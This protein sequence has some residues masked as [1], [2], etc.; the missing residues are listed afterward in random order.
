MGM[1]NRVGHDFVD[2][3]CLEKKCRDCFQPNPYKC[4]KLNQW[5]P[6][7]K[8]LVI[9]FMLTDQCNL[10]CEFCWQKLSIPT[11]GTFTKELIDETLEYFY[12]NYNEYSLVIAVLGGE[13]TLYPELI[14]EIAKKQDELYHKISIRVYSNGLFNP[15]KI[16]KICETYENITFQIS[17]NYEII[18][19]KGL[20]QYIEVASL[21]I[22]ED[23]NFEQEYKRILE[24]KEMG[25]HLMHINFDLN[26]IKLNNPKKYHQDCI[27]FM[28]KLIPLLSKEFAISNFIDNP[29][30]L[31]KIED[32]NP[33][34]N[35]FPDGKFY[36]T[37]YKYSPPVGSLLEGVD[38]EQFYT[39][40]SDSPCRSCPNDDIC[41]VRA[42][43]EFIQSDGT[44]QREKTVCLKNLMEAEI[45]RKW[46]INM[47]GE[48]T[49]LLRGEGHLK[50]KM[51]R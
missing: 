49:L 36:K 14:E 34:I 48:D 6:R 47:F 25:Y 31:H 30:Y 7:K 10:N 9:A 41:S 43:Q 26:N 13:P 40:F 11:F 8:F 19:Y 2:S 18:K 46:H 15:E 51:R 28:E 4:A 39:V 42:E 35:V 45:A 23:T 44:E 33:I 38:L 24:I 16:L 32:Y 17:Q 29:F 50:R 22:T 37:H 21:V 12:N 3:N 20:K 5:N 27:N 1:Y